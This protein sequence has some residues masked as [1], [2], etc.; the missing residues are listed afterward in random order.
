MFVDLVNEIKLS[1]QSIETHLGLL[2]A[3]FKAI[4]QNMDRTVKEFKADLTHLI[5]QRFDNLKIG[6]LSDTTW[7]LTDKEFNELRKEVGC[8]RS[9]LDLIQIESNETRI[10]GKHR[11]TLNSS[12]QKTKRLVRRFNLKKSS[13]EIYKSVASDSKLVEVKKEKEINEIKVENDLTI[14][15]RRQRP[16][17]LESLVWT[18]KDRLVNVS[19]QECLRVSSS[20]SQNGSDTSCFGFFIGDE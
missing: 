10:R 19:S 8:V 2:C 16:A 18:Q 20:S 14:V 9:K 11:A 12:L 13:G 17:V 1:T 4:E 5:S 6:I 3:Q 15:R 7:K